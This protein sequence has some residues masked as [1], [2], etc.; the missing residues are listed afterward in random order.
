MSLDIN[1]WG[2]ISV[3]TALEAFLFAFFLWKTA[4]PT[5]VTRR[6]SFLLLVEV[7]TLLTSGSGIPLLFDYQ[8]S[9]QTNTMMDVLHHL[10]DILMLV[11]YPIFVAHA[12]P[13]PLLKR[14][15]GVPGRI[16]LWSVGL[17]L[18][19]WVALDHTKIFVSSFD[20]DMVLYLV[21]CIMFLLIF[22]VSLFG[23]KTASSR[24]AREKMRAFVLAFGIRDI[25]WASV[26]L[27]AATGWINSEGREAVINLLYAGSTA[28]YIPIVAYGIL[29]VQLLDIEIRLQSTVR[30]TVLA[31]AFIAV[32]YLISESANNFISNQLGDILGFV[33]CAV[34]AIFLAPLHRWADR[35]ARKLVRVDNEIPGYADDRR[36]QIYNSAVE[37]ALAYGQVNRGQ[38]ALLDRL[39]DSLNISAGDAR[40]IELELQFDRDAVPG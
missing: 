15:T 8:L 26:Y 28:L 30:N 19:V 38:L 13:L 33:V 3:L 36:M 40:R 7:V 35:F 1:L 14:V 9:A 37:E 11:L 21:M 23:L 24:L 27:A 20:P 2:L 34:L 18:L 4:V 10:G 29:K 31:S 32:F 16:A 6:F 5:P 12:L 39:K 25:A 22:I 17:L